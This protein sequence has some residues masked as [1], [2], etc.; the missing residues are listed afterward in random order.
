MR[1]LGRS[2]LIH[3]FVCTVAACLLRTATLVAS[4]PDQSPDSP[5]RTITLADH[6]AH[7]YAIEEVYWRHRIWPNENRK[8]KPPLEAIIS[9]RQIE[10][11]VEDYLRKSQLVANQRGWS[12]TFS[13]LQAE[14]DRMASHTK[15]PQV[16]RELFAALGNDPFLIAECLVRANVAERL[17]THSTIA[18]VSPAR[19]NSFEGSTPTSKE[20][21]IDVAT[22]VDNADYKLP[23]IAKGCSDDTWT[24]TTSVNAPDAREGHTGVWTG[25]EMIIWGGAFTDNGWHN[26]NTGGRY[27]PATDSWIATSTTNAPTLRWRHCAV[28]TGREMIVW[29]GYG[30]DNEFLATGGRYDPTDDSWTA[31][32]ISDAPTARISPTAVWTGGEMIVW[33][34]Y[35]YTNGRFNTGGRY[36]PVTDSWVAIG[37]LNVPEARWDHTAEWTGSEMIIWG[38]TN[39]TIGL[40]TGGR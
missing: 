3:C 26:L 39:Q 8:P 4:S 34:G 27:N 36:D 37:R 23:Q 40:N 33:G 22:P 17:V 28:W 15:K 1:P 14:M 29:G 5:R 9:Q 10:Q 16:L 24:G 20:N 21:R 25:S 31:T 35:N 18:D 38:G 12:I 30:G 32:S 19:R 7:Q 2:A 6:L 13:E 11:K